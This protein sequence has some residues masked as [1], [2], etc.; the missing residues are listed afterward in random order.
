MHL[1]VFVCTLFADSKSVK[2]QTRSNRTGTDPAKN[3]T[4]I[5][6]VP[7]WQKPDRTESFRGVCMRN[8]DELCDLETRQKEHFT[9]EIRRSDLFYLHDE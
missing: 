4:G 6:L 5:G 2:T 8:V 3:Q 9:K 1:N 7:R